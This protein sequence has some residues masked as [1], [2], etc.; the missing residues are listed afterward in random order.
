M[1]IFDHAHVNNDM[2]VNRLGNS[3]PQFP[4]L[5]KCRVTGSFTKLSLQMVW[6]VGFRSS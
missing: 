4:R 6:S 2:L 3:W 5:H 1:Y